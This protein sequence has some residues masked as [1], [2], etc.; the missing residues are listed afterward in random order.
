LQL[1]LLQVAGKAR[2]SPN[3]GCFSHQRFSLSCSVPVTEAVL[4]AFSSVTYRPSV[5]EYICNHFINARR[6][7]YRTNQLCRQYT[8]TNYARRI[9]S[10]SHVIFFSIRLNQKIEKTK[11]PQAFRK[12]NRKKEKDPIGLTPKTLDS[13][14]HLSLM[15]FNQNIPTLCI[16]VVYPTVCKS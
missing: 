13:F 15:A 6:R 11:E 4:T 9:Y 10:N 1:L 3:R 14:N 2:S 8:T 16:Y 12:S 5:S 7:Q